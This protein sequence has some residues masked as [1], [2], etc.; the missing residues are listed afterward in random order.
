MYQLL[1]L[2]PM[3][4]SANCVMMGLGQTWRHCGPLDTL[5]LAWD[6]GRN[7]LS[8]SDLLTEVYLAD[9]RCLDPVNPVLR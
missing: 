8:V 2:T 7:C 6:L 5:Y 3:T 4:I 1:E 9:V